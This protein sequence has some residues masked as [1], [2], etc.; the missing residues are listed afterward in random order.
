MPTASASENAKMSSS[1][2]NCAVRA[3]AMATI[4]SGATL[5]TPTTA[6]STG[7]SAIWT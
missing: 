5:D 7:H 3:S 4:A 6:T 1:S 2:G